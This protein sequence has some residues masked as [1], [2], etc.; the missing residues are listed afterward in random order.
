MSEYAIR[1]QAAYI[2]AVVYGDSGMAEAF[3]NLLAKEMGR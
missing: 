1:L 3:A 2:E